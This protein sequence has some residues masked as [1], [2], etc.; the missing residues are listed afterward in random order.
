[1]DENQKNLISSKET[2]ADVIESLFSVKGSGF[3]TVVKVVLGIASIGWVADSILPILQAL[4]LYWWTGNIPDALS[5]KDSYIKLTFPIIWFVIYVSFLFIIRQ[6]KLKAL[7]YKIQGSFPHRGLII[8]LSPLTGSLNLTEL[9][10]QV[11]EKTLDIEQFYNNSNWGQLA[12]TVAHHSYLL[13]KCWVF[14]TSKSTDEFTV[15]KKLIDFVSQKFD[16]REIDCIE[17]NI[18]DENDLSQMALMVSD[19][20]KSVGGFESNLQPRDVISNYTGG[21]VAMSGGI[22]MATLNENREIEYISQKYL[23]KLSSKLL[24]N[25]DKNLAI[26]SSKTNLVMVE[27]LNL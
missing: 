24:R 27:K 3:W 22:I 7:Q 10:K 15:A 11:D 8:S 16:G 17:K 6:N 4:S 5:V 18:E 1:M 26:V 12:F 14:T 19:V 25:I 13:Q 2:L 23:R 9:E 20:Y 21:T